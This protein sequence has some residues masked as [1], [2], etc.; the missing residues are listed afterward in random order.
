VVCEWHQTTGLDQDTYT[1]TPVNN[2]EVYV[3]MT[4]SLGCTTGNPATSNTTTMIVNP[5]LPV[6][7]TAAPDQNNICLGI[8]VL[9]SQRLLQTAAHLLT[10]G[11]LNGVSALAWTQDTYSFTPVNGDQVYVVMTSD[12]AGCLT[13]NP[14]TSNTTTMIVN[15]NPV[16]VSIAAD[17]NPVC[18]GEVMLLLR[19]PR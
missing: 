8:S 9:L 3:V 17:A 6:S 11:I 4:S 5:S 13:G 12:L 19:Q 14:A 16:S 2:D 7:V 10:S 15:D 1:Y 18:Q